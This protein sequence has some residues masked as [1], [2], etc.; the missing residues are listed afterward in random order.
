MKSNKTALFIHGGAI[1]GAFGA[2]AVCGLAESGVRNFD[3]VIG[4][5]ASVP[6][7]AYFTSKQFDYI[8]KIWTEEVGTKRFVSHW[9]LIKGK[10]IYNMEYLIR[11]VFK[12]KYPLDVQAIYNSKSELRIPLF[13]YIHNKLEIWRVPQHP[14][15]VFWN[16]LQA[17]TAVHDQYIQW[18]SLLQPYVDADLDP[19]AL[20]RQ[21]IV[22]PDWNVVVVVNHHEM[23]NTF[24]KWAGVRIFRLLQSRNFPTGVKEALRKRDYLI[25]SGV[26]AF[27]QFLSTHNPL[28]ISPPLSLK[29]GPTS[30]LIRDRDEI[31]QLFAAGEKIATSLHAQ[32][33]VFA[34]R[35]LE[36]DL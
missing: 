27:K 11:E 6:T 30:V 18:N 28:I 17:A 14:K 5:S 2:G 16:I 4:T 3:V 21:E 33:N 10:P 1:K 35:S 8:R 9:N 20:Y 19:F 34:A 29:L 13:N 22:P 36:L 23:G 24:R 12:K 7:S 31:Q 25:E 32:L 15:N 26:T